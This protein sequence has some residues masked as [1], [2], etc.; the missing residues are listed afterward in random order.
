MDSIVDRIVE[1]LGEEIRHLPDNFYNTFDYTITGKNYTHPITWGILTKIMLSIDGVKH[2]AID[3]HLNIK[4]TKFQP[5]LAA[6]S[7]I[8]PKL[9]FKLFLDYESPN[10]S[11]SRIV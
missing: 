4:R 1:R 10:S 5:D 8:E 3:F 7:E 6:I 9:K 2:V 11:D